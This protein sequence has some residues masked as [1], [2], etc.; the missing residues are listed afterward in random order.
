MCSDYLLHYGTP[1]HSGR[2]PYG[3]GKRPYQS[4]GLVKSSASALQKEKIKKKDISES[5]GVSYRRNV[6]NRKINLD[7]PV[8]LKRGDKVQHISG[9]DLDEIKKGNLYV[10]YEQYDNVLYRS[11]LGGKLKNAGYDAKTVQL[12]L[13]KDLKA[14]SPNEQF[15]IYKNF[16]KRNDSFK[17]YMESFYKSKGRNMR[18]KSDEEEYVDFIESLENSSEIQK[19]FYNQLKKNGYNAVLDEHDRLG[20][21]MQAKKPLILMDALD[22]VSDMKI[23]EISR[24]DVVLGLRKLYE[25]RRIQND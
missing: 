12:T 24:E 16:K 10:T 18:P 17:N 2:Y 6:E 21:W 22:V 7:E 25:L 23:D 8:S 5:Y 3:S 11:L 14:P 4:S 19:S 20:S 9:I 15:E 13:G 1:R